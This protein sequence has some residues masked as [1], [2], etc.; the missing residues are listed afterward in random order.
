VFICEKQKSRCKAQASGKK[1]VT[2]IQR[3]LAQGML[4]L[5]IEP[6]KGN[7]GLNNENI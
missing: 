3:M 2:I 7:Q 4:F 6:T 5:R 1:E